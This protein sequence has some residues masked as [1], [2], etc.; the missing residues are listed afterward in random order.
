MRTD[1]RV[2]FPKRKDRIAVEMGRADMGK[3]M[4]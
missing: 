2:S 1:Q 4:V 3:T